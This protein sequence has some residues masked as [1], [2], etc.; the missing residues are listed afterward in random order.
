MSQTPPALADGPVCN[1]RAQDE[2]AALAARLTNLERAN[3]ELR[4]RVWRYERERA[5]FKL[6]LERIPSRIGCSGRP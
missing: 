5:E 2:R 4:Q 3:E 1:E 6:R